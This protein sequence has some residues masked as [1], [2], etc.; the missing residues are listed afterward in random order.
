MEQT[1]QKSRKWL[2]WVGLVGL[3]VV[4][5]QSLNIGLALFKEF[6]GAL[7]LYTFEVILMVLLVQISYSLMKR[8]KDER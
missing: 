3:V 2:R 6:S 1:K 8:G 4:L 5:Y 7:L